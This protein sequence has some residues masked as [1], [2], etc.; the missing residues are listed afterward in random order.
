MSMTPAAAL[1]ALVLAGCTAGTTPTPDPTP[2]PAPA[3]TVEPMQTVSVTYT[4]LPDGVLSP[5]AV[6]CEDGAPI[7]RELLASVVH[8]EDDYTTVSFA[9]P[10]PAGRRYRTMAVQLVD[11]GTDEVMWSTECHDTMDGDVVRAAMGEIDAVPGYLV[12]TYRFGTEQ[13]GGYIAVGP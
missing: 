7:D 4:Y 13:S 1:V 5:M 2:T 6:T 11:Y 12:D 10:T 3:A 8:V 9:W